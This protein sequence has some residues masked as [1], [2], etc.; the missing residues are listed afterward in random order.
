MVKIR[1]FSTLRQQ[2]G[3]FFFSCWL[4]LVLVMGSSVWAG[5]L[6]GWLRFLTFARIRCS[7][8]ACVQCSRGRWAV[9]AGGGD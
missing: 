6:A 8:G 3:C 9:T 5:W 2:A 7:A 4:A 1:F